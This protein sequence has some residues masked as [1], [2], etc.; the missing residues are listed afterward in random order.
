MAALA[1]SRPASVTCDQPAARPA[2][3]TPFFDH[4]CSRAARRQ[5]PSPP[6]R[7]SKWRSRRVTPAARQARASS[8]TTTALRAFVQTAM[9]AAASPR[10]EKPPGKAATRASAI[11][12]PFRVWPLSLANTRPK[13]PRWIAT[14]SAT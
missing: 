3:S 4:W 7:A 6:P 11:D 8:P 10:Q 12:P 14:A 13:T 1:A 5:A 2:N 9:S